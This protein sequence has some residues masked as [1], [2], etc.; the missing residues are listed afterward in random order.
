MLHEKLQGGAELGSLE[1]HLKLSFHLERLGHVIVRCQTIAEHVPRIA[2]NFEFLIDQSYLPQI[3]RD[4]RRYFL[5]IT[6]A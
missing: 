2:L 1:G 6:D 5:A 4:A 3:A